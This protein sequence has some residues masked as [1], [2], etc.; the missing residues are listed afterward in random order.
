[1]GDTYTLF[2]LS[3]LQMYGLTSTNLLPTLCLDLSFRNMLRLRLDSNVTV[4]QPPWNFRYFLVTGPKIEINFCYTKKIIQCS[5]GDKSWP[6]CCLIQLQL[7]KFKKQI[8]LFSFPKNVR[9]SFPD[10]ALAFQGRIRKY[11]LLEAQY[12]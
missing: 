6:K 5:G 12:S 7:R 1:M 11:F 10:S 9:K 2:T 8:I 3:G 4:P